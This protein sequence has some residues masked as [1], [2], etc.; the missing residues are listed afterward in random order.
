MKE[1]VQVTPDF[2]YTKYQRFKLPFPVL[3]VWMLSDIKSTVNPSES[4]TVIAGID[5]EFSSRTLY[6]SIPE[7]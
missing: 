5:S 4:C 1:K 6:I 2:S 7:Q 3:T